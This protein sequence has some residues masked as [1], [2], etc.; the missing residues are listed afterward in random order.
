MS[1]ASHRAAAI[2]GAILAGGRGRRMGGADKGWILWQGRPLVEQVAERLRPQ[3]GRLLISANRNLERYAALGAAVVADERA[4]Q[5]EFAGPLAGMLAV[6]RQARGDW[7]AFVPCD[8]PALPR[9]LVAR[10]AEAGAGTRA[11]VATCGGVVQPVFCLLP[12]TLAPRLQEL[13]EQGERRPQEM[14]RQVGAVAVPFAD[15]A[16]F[17]NINEAGGEPADGR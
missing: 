9:A 7:V 10:L 16:A 15:A 14:L 17:A 3:V 13:L 11:A 4:G 2:D 5:G 1:L 8:A 12:R 6:L